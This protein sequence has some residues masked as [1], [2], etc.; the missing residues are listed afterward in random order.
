M[1]GHEQGLPRVTSWFFWNF[2]FLFLYFFNIFLIFFKCTHVNPGACH[3]S[4]RGFFEFFILFFWIFLNFFKCTRVNPGACHVSLRGFFEFF[5][6]F[7]LNFF[8][9]FLNFFKCP[10][11]NPVACH[12]SKSILYIQFGPYICYFCSI[13]FKFLLTLTNLVRM[14]DVTKFIFYI[15]V[16]MMWILIYY[17]KI[18]NKKCE[19]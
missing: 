7:F 14:E 16:I 3:V 8:W 10:L 4:L 6:L 2:L 1:N 19:F 5:I 17:I 15:K 18:F 11:V 9:I 12:V 13:M